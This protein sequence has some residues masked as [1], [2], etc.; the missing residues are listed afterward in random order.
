[1]PQIL[2]D[3]LYDYS[4]DLGWAQVSQFTVEDGEITDIYLTLRGRSNE[5]S[6]NSSTEKNALVNTLTDIGKADPGLSTRFAPTSNTFKLL[7]GISAESSKYL[8]EL[9]KMAN[10]LDYLKLNKEADYLDDIIKKSSDRLIDQFTSDLDEDE[11]KEDKD[12][13]KPED[14]VNF[15]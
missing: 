14:Q 6:Y 3:E 10:H 2:P 12:S 7:G 1:M 15:G 13:D 9:I 5:I 4:V 11:E 8:L